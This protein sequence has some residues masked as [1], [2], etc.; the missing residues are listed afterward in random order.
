MDYSN[1]L[2]DNEYRASVELTLCQSDADR[3]FLKIFRLSG[4]VIDE[5]PHLAVIGETELW[6]PIRLDGQ[7]LLL[8]S[9]KGKNPIL[10]L[11]GKQI[12]T[13]SLLRQYFVDHVKLLWHM[14]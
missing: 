13:C 4:V 6:Q 2:I 14:M 11:T 10:A 5:K 1:D 3:D 7:I 8:K 12:N 9:L